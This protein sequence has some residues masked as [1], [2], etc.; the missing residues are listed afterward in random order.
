MLSITYRTADLARWGSGL[1]RPLHAAEFDMNFWTLQVA[2][3][4]LQTDLPAAAVGISYF[5][6]VGA[7]FYVHMDDHTVLGPYTLPTLSWNF[8]GVWTTA[9]VYAVG[10]VFTHG[11]ATYLV[12]YAHTSASPFDANATDGLGHNYYGLLL[13]G[14]SYTPA[15]TTTIATTTHTLQASNANTY[16]RCTH[17]DGCEITVPAAATL[18]ATVDDEWNFRQVSGNLTIIAAGGV[19]ING[20]VGYD[21]ATEIVGATITLKM[22][23]ENEF[24]VWGLLKVV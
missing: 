24:D 9:T 1:G 19:T 17:A 2:V 4:Q 12:T 8:V 14:P 21:T 18:N 3:E 6:V 11:T 5:S 22:V 13:E 10:D 7:E 20:A 23:A 15:V 16:M